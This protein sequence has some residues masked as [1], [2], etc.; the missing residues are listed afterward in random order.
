V[1]IHFNEQSVKS[2]RNS[3]ME[4]CANDHCLDNDTLIVLCYA[5]FC[6]VFGFIVALLVIFADKRRSHTSKASPTSNSNNVEA[7][8]PNKLDLQLEEV[9]KSITKLEDIHRKSITQI[10]VNRK[11]ES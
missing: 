9:Q 10:P 4:L 3:G 2:S 7:G 1:F 5:A 11:G 6:V 8:K